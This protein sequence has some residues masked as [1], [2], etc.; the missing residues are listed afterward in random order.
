MRK[1]NLT[2]SECGYT[3]DV[4][5][6]ELMMNDKCILC[7]GRMEITEQKK[8]IEDIVDRDCLDKMRYQIEQL[9]DK[10]VWEIIEQFINPLTRIEYRKLFIKAGGEVPKVNIGDL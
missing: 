5:D 2:C 7:G 6:N 9:G 1:I 10:K 3:I 8:T 4:L